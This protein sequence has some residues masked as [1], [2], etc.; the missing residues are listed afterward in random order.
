MFSIIVA[1][2]KNF[3]IG[4]DGKMPWH[5]KEDL[6]W[7]KEKTHNHTVVMGKKTFL[8]IGRILPNRK[9][10]SF[11]LQLLTLKLKMEIHFFQN[12]I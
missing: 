12:L 4:K 5:I 6:Q 7:F 2:D 1:F 10:K 8:S 3:C 9:K 11:I